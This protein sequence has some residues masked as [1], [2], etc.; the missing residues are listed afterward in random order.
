MWFAFDN[1]MTF[2][3]FLSGKPLSEMGHAITVPALLFSFSVA[4]LPLS[5]KGICV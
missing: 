3:I 4:A 2:V 5:P 1:A